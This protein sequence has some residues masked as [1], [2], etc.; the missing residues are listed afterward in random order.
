MRATRAKGLGGFNTNR[1][2][3]DT[4]QECGTRRSDFMQDIEV[5]T[6]Q[7]IAV[8]PSSTDFASEMER[9]LVGSEDCDVDDLGRTEELR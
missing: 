8:F 2:F 6:C 3:F 5:D 4:D 1:G 7:I 9:Y